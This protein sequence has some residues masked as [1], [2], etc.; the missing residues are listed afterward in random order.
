MTAPESCP[1]GYRIVGPLSAPR[2]L[3]DWPRGFA[4]YCAADPRAR[5]DREAY[6]SLFQFGA[7]FA[8]YFQAGGSPRGFHGPCWSPWLWFDIDRPD[9]R[10]STALNDARILWKHLQERFTVSD[11][12][13]LVFFS[14]S[15]GFHLGLP[16]V[17]IG[18]EPGPAFPRIAGTLARQIALDAGV[19]IDVGIYDHV[20]AFR[21]PNSRHPVSALHKRRLRPKELIELPAEGITELA[22]RPEGFE[23]DEAAGNA[24]NEALREAWAAAEAEVSRQME[25]MEQRRQAIARGEDQ[26]RINQ[27]TLQ[28][29]REGALDGERARRLFSA[30]AN[31]AECGAPLNLCRELLTEAAR[32]SGLQPR[33]VERQIRCGFEHVWK[34]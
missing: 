33:E 6:L 28:F 15:K 30:S 3:V 16:I 1:Y 31:L 18:A 27:L 26:P 10:L 23:I 32:D 20:R 4:A 25:A 2:Y 9:G 29:I 19:V 11:E 17:G 34:E 5:P 8:R 12:A 22:R 7:E 14:G 13:L 21:A 24:V